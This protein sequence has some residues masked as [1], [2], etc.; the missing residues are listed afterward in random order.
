MVKDYNVKKDIEFVTDTLNIDINHFALESGIAKRTLFY[1][2]KNKPSLDV[3]NRVYSTIYNLGFRITQT[4]CEIFKEIINPDEILLFHG[5]KNG[6]KE[7]KENGSRTNC[8]F[9]EGFYLTE[10]E[11]SA[12]SFV[13]DYPESSLYAFKIFIND[14]NIIEFSYDFEWMLAISLFRE[15]IN[16]FISNEKIQ[17]IKDKVQSAD[18][19]IAPIADNKMFE[20]LNQFANGEIT[21]IQALHSLSASRLGKQY[22]IKSKKALSR[23][24]CIERMFLSNEEK[25]TAV[26]SNI[27]RSKVIET[28][29]N[30]SKRE[31]RGQGKYIDE[32]LK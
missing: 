8:D 25:Q 23:L 1:S 5:S 9:G 26:N 10:N 11:N 16:E 20:I 7:I 31:Y 29:L 27:E 28:K 21:D 18:I 24:V 2:L 3:L 32:V 30:Y 15:K 14:L 19:V 12:I 22:V 6:I 17:K 4:K 13:S